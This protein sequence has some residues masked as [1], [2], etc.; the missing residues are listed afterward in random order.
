MY[1]T[2]CFLS[3]VVD[4]VRKEHLLAWLL[5]DIIFREILLFTICMLVVE[6]LR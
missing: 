1:L 4:S 2:T 6:G 3:G 5:R